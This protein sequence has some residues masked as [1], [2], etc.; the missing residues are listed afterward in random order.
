MTLPTGSHEAHMVQVACQEAAWTW[1]RTPAEIYH[2][3][4]YIDGN[5][6]CALYGE[7]LQDG[8]AGFGDSPELAMQDFNKAWSA[9]IGEYREIVDEIEPRQFQSWAK[10]IAKQA[11]KDDSDG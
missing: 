4:I 9:T 8:V 7:N 5:Q 10:R 1:V 11:L 3:R 6:W 2:P